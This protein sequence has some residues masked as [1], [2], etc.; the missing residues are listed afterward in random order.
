MPRTHDV[1]PVQV[2]IA[3]RSIAS[4]FWKFLRIFGASQEAL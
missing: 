1:D 2:H 4:A 3:W